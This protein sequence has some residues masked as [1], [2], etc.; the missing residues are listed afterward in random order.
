VGRATITADGAV[1]R[2]GLISDTHI[3]E[4]RAELWPQAFA[5]LAGVDAIL[6][7]G[8]IHDLRV[9]DQLSA[10]APTYCARG[11]GD[12][13]GGGRPV[14]PDDPRI[15]P[16]WVLDVVVPGA[17][18]LRIGIIHDLPVP[19]HP[20]HL[21]VERVTQRRFGVKRLDVI[22]FGD[23]HIESIDLISGTLCINPGSPTYPH[24]LDTQLGT[25]GFLE[26]D[27]ESVQAS[28]A[29]LTEASYEITQI[30]APVP[31]HTSIQ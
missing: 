16:V 21:T 2:I 6:H 12:E 20:P 27:G 17:P 24:N 28:L 29:Q 30:H 15:H 31:H 5:A 9:L 26:I 19:E 3:P 1:L 10:I 13:G 11:N 22:I 18:P 4:A 23:T 25:I 14:T 8:D 7:G